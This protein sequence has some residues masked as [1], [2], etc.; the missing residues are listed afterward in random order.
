MTF[1]FISLIC[2]CSINFCG[3]N[4]ENSVNTTSV[5]RITLVC[6][7][8]YTVRITLVQ[9]GAP[10]VCGLPEVRARAKWKKPFCCWSSFS[11]AAGEQIKA[12]WRRG[13]LC[14]SPLLYLLL[15]SLPKNPFGSDGL[16]RCWKKSKG[17]ISVKSGAQQRSLGVVHISFCPYTR[18]SLLLFLNINPLD[19]G[20]DWGLYHNSA[21][22][23]PLVCYFVSHNFILLFSDYEK[24]YVKL[25]LLVIISIFS[26]IFIVFFI[27]NWT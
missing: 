4:C 9:R 10:A 11:L 23:A 19:S 7:I 22:R 17:D 2:I 12:T 14:L 1:P 26:Y 25:P 6:S 8:Y 15:W 13:A 5:C 27:V 3:L 20:S 16:F 21:S 24:F 18:H